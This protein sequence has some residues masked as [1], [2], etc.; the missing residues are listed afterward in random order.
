MKRLKEKDNIFFF[1]GLCYNAVAPEVNLFP[2]TT[3]TT[4]KKKMT[5]HAFLLLYF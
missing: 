4:T 5:C 1:F 3:T 2:E